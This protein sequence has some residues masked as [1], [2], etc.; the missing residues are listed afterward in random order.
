MTTAD[1]TRSLDEIRRAGL[2][3]LGRELGPAGM[4][5]FLRQFIKPSGDFTAERDA[6]VGNPSVDEI[7]DAIEKRFSAEGGIERL[8]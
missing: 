3:A 6:L 1:T 4:V 8:P 7:C 2:Q 5:L